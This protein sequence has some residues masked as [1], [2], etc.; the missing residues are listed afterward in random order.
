MT[1][2][3][4]S[5]VKGRKVPCS[6]RMSLVSGSSS[7]VLINQGTNQRSCCVSMRDNCSCFMVKLIRRNLLCN[8]KK[9]CKKKKKGSISFCIKNTRE[10]PG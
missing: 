8:E 1:N 6:Q 4:W 9:S 10:K 2:F 3:I 5:R 7:N